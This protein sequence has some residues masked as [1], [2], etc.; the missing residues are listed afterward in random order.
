MLCLWGATFQGLHANSILKPSHWQTMNLFPA[1]LLLFLLLLSNVANAQT[2]VAHR[3]ASHDAPENT[4]AAFKLAWDQ[5]ADAI[6]GD[7]HF[8]SDQK[9]VCI[10]DKDTER[11]CPNVD[12]LNV[13]ETDLATLQNL[14][15][16]S[17]KGSEFVDETMPTLGDVLATVPTGKSIF[18]EI[19]CGVEILSVLEKE[20]SASNLKPKQIVLISFNSDVIRQARQQMPKYQANWLTSYKS[21]GDEEDARWTPELADVL[22]TLTETGASGIGSQGNDQVVDQG[23]VSAI[24][25]AGLE[26]HA[27]TIDDPVYAKQLV[28][29]G[30]KSITTNRPEFLRQKLQSSIENSP[31]AASR[32]EVESK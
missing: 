1:R 27:W 28:S 16:G 22:A 29:F 31:T 2:I 14:D 23:F 8:T 7:F 20:L 6:E 18:I 21:T 12:N 5:G 19:K 32:V 24:M 10:H 11:V 3:G 9:I 4:L 17:W 13:A 30:A 25:D 26:F 15:V